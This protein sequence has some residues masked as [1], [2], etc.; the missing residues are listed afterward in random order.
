MSTTEPPSSLHSVVV[1][2]LAES[3]LSDP[4]AVAE[5]VA[6][7]TP[8][9]LIRDFYTDAVVSEVRAV[10][11]AQR[12]RAMSNALNPSRSPKLAQRRDWW[13]DMLAS[14]IHVGGGT[15]RTLGECGAEQLTF[16]EVERR[17]DAER[18]LRRAESFKALRN[19]LRK[20]KVNTVGELPADAARSA[21]AAVAA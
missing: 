15:W 18:E 3:E 7:A 19:L 1:A 10:M 12:N 6:A 13:A 21:V 2:V 20:H 8:P 17:R 5:L 9:D 14:R 16:A 11:G 4:R